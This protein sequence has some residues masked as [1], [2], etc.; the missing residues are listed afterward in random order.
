[1][2]DLKLDTKLFLEEV[3]AFKERYEAENL[4]P[5]SY[6]LEQE[7]F[8]LKVQQAEKKLTKKNKH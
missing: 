2:E 4:E 5:F 3:K 8:Q 6:F 7:G 1:M